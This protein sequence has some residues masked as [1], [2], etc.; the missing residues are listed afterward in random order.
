MAKQGAIRAGGNPPPELY[1]SLT[2]TALYRAVEVL[3]VDVCD[4]LRMIKIV[5]NV[6]VAE[7]IYIVLKILQSTKI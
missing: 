4:S 5:Q 6:I 7:E 2:T 3:K 1:Q